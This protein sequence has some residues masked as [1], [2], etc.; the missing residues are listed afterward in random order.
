M[1]TGSYSP[2]AAQ[3]IMNYFFGIGSSSIE[4]A[5]EEEQ[6]TFTSLLDMSPPLAIDYLNC[7][8]ILKNK[9]PIPFK[10]LMKPQEADI[11]KE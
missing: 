7:W 3:E 1:I 4:P 10:C 11:L 6:S 8:L 5:T 9:Q 2:V